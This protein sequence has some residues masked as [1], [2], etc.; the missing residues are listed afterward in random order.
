M[1]STMKWDPAMRSHPVNYL[2]SRQA[3]TRELHDFGAYDEKGRRIGAEIRTGTLEFRAIEADET[4]SAWNCAPGR[5]FYVIAHATR[6]GIPYGPCQGTVYYVS[7][8]ERAAA[9][10]KYMADA[11]KRAEGKARKAQ[12]TA[13]AIAARIT[14][15]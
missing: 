5:Y 11:R 14:R 13:A 15:L 6:N 9:I 4:L 10:A 12:A 8:Q 7:E 3:E 2:E 1:K